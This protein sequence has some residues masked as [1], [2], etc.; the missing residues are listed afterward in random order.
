[1][2]PWR[3]DLP[4]PDDGPVALDIE[5]WPFTAHFHAD[6]TLRLTIAGADINRWSPENFVSGHDLLNNTAPHV[7]YTGGEHA[8]RLRLPIAHPQ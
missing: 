5:I 2:R 7:L 4:L 3:S 6:E 1:M 8:S